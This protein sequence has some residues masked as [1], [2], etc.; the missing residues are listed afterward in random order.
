[1]FPLSGLANTK[2]L[3]SE[4]S[5]DQVVDYMV[6]CNVNLR[7]LMCRASTTTW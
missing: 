1:M 7:V 5:V 6:R 3:L 4:L 2:I